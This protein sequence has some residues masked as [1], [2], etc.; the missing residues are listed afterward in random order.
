MA[1]S[2]PEGGSILDRGKTAGARQAMIA[3][4]GLAFLAF[5]FRKAGHGRAGAVIKT[6][7][8]SALNLS[9]VIKHFVR[10]GHDARTVLHRL[11]EDATVLSWS[12]HR[13]CGDAADPVVRKLGRVAMACAGK[14]EELESSS[15]NPAWRAMLWKGSSGRR[16][17]RQRPGDC[18][19]LFQGCRR[20]WSERLPPGGSAR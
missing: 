10:D 4:D 18:A 6:A 3:L 16:R 19:K 9:E 1:P 8:L 13:S 12:R 15:W 20:Q 5:L 7:C 11:E 17:G 2:S 14:R